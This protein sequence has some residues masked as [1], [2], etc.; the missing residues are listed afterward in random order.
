MSGHYRTL[1]SIDHKLGLDTAVFGLIVDRY[2]DRFV[3]EG[4]GTGRVFGSIC[5]PDANGWVVTPREKGEMFTP[6]DAVLVTNVVD[7]E[8]YVVGADKATLNAPLLIRMCQKYPWARAILH[9]HEQLDGVPTEPFAIPSS[10]DD[11]NRV[12]PGPVFNIEGHGFIACL[13][14]KLNIVD[15]QVT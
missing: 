15:Y 3:H 11:G 4:N 1:L 6:K 10:L 5:V 13:D 9:L 14:W 7:N 12:I 2:R 8:V